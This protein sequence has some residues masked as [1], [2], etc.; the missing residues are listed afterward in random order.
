MINI[1]NKLLLFIE[2]IFTLWD[3][4]VILV[5]YEKCGAPSINNPTKYQRTSKQECIS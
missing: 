5:K 4:K 1:I 3:L 2:A